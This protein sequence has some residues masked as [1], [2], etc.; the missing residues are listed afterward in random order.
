M[1]ELRA[2]C[3][4]HSLRAQRLLQPHLEGG[5]R[6]MWWMEEQGGSA[7]RLPMRARTMPLTAMHCAL[8]VLL[9]SMINVACR[10]PCVQAPPR[11]ALQQQ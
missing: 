2:D 8:N 11:Q 1:A 9:I 5:W 10:C 3:T 7:E 4:R 6:C